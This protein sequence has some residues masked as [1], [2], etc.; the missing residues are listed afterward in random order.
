VIFSYAFDP[1]GLG[2]DSL[3][4]VVGREGLLAGNEHSLHLRIAGW[5]RPTSIRLGATRGD[6]AWKAS[7]TAEIEHFA[8]FARSEGQPIATFDDGRTALAVVRAAY[9]SAAEGRTVRL[10]SLGAAQ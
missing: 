10:E 3:F 8:G 4:A 6:R 2:P 7:I 9:E 1:P 5:S